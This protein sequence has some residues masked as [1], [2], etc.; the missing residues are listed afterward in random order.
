M[1]AA[2]QLE[3]REHALHRI[4]KGDYIA[5]SNDLM[6]MYRVHAYEDGKIHGLDVAYER[7]TFWRI[8]QRPMPRTDDEKRIVVVGD[9]WD[10]RVWHEID[11]FLPTRRAAL[12]KV[13]LA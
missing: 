1:T 10:D 8:A 11:W 7:R 6:T 3:T 9:P 4:G 12:E 5:F 13:G 2:Q